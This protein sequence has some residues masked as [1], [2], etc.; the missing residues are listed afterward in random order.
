MASMD[1]LAASEVL[2]S[3]NLRRH[4]TTKVY[5]FRTRKLEVRIK[6]NLAQGE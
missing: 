6:P 5:V 4:L 1:V 3:E 2:Y